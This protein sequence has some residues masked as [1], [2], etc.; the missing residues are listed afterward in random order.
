[1]SKFCPKCGVLVSN[2]ARHLN[3]KRC[4]SQHFQEQQRNVFKED[5]KK[6]MREEMSELLAKYKGQLNG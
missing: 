6:R 1:M 5:R 4:D 2:L 3:R